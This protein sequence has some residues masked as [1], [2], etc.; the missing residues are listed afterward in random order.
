MD[1]EMSDGYLV[2]SII[3]PSHQLAH[4]PASQITQG[5]KSRMPYYAEQITVRQL[6]DMVAFL[7]SRYGVRR[8]PTQYYF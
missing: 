5:G 1:Y 6:T 3:N 7:Q 4:Y 8:L 2:T